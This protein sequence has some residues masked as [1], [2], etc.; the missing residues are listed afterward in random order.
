[1]QQ[2]WLLK[3]LEK[4]D[5]MKRMNLFVILAVLMGLMVFMTN[6]TA[7]VTEVTVT[8]APPTFTG[9]CP[10]T[11]VFTGKITT[12]SSDMVSYGW[13]RSDGAIHPVKTIEF[14]RPGTK[15][16]TYNWI[17][18]TDG[19]S[20]SG[21]VVLETLSPN[22][23]T[24]NKANFTLKCLRARPEKPLPVNTLRPPPGE[25][26]M[27]AMG[28]PDPAAYDIR[29]QIVQR[30][31]KFNGRVR[32]T[33][34]I[35]NI[36]RKAFKP[37]HNQAKAYLYEMPPGAST[38]GKILAQKVIGD[39]TAGETLSLNYERNWTTTPTSGGEFPPI[40]RLQILYD[41][42]VSKNTNTANDDC[43]QKNNK[44]V[45]NGSEINNMFAK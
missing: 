25:R 4:G 3:H 44:K 10:K 33:G 39:L 41:P 27:S 16:F 14:T 5:E 18:G 29:F 36:G 13:K 2:K 8:V 42:D 7:K 40:Y 26:G 43:S 6:L 23:M 37:V 45:R 32:I 15:D 20:C 11:F 34:I 12:D 28:C 31:D 17:V 22:I 9:N 35:K 1:M 24:S 30:K 21:W 38:G 19:K